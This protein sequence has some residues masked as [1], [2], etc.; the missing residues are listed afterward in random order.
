MSDNVIEA[1]FTVNKTETEEKSYHSILQVWRAILEPA[2]EGLLKD[3]ITPMWAS[4]IV[5]SYQGVVFSDMPHMKKRYYERIVELRD[6]LDGFITADDECLNV[7]DEKEDLEHNRATY[8]EVLLQ[9]QLAI[10]TWELEWDCMNPYAGAEIAAIA[11]VQQMFFGSQN[12]QGLT[13][14]LE[15]IK[16][17]LTDEDRANWTETI[18]NHRVEMIARTQEEK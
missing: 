1:D 16:L 8:L 2:E 15:S 3:P 5:G 6:I 17:D 4:K 14:Y 12:R 7:L 10:A 11:E 9:W 13:A 18:E